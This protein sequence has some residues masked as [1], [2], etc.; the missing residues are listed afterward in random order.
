VSCSAPLDN[1][2]AWGNLND[3][4]SITDFFGIDYYMKAARP[5]NAGFQF[6]GGLTHWERYGDG[7]LYE[8][9]EGGLTGSYAAHL[10]RETATGQYFGLVQRKIPVEPDTEYRLSVWVRTNTTSGSVAAALGVWSQDASLNH[11]TDFGWISGENEWVQMSG[12]WR[13]R[14]DE[15]IIQVALYGSPDFVGE[16]YFDGL[17][18][19]KT[20]PQNGGFEDGLKSWESYGDGTSYETADGGTEGSSS[21]YLKRVAATGQY[22]GLLQRKIPCEPNTIYRLSLWLKTNAGSG[23]A[24]AGL[25]NWSGDP[26]QNTHRD[27]G[28][29]GGNTDWKQISGTWTSGEN[30]R[31]L[32]VVLYATPDFS[33]EAFFDNLA[34]K[35]WAPPLR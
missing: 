2:S 33:G 14:P 13:S 7:T 22:F 15:T 5:L 28:W 30:E 19:E 35:R 24:A 25:G 4:L 27:F 6:Q 29:T 31:T 8:R 20:S 23:A 17:A 12:I 9:A 34:L 10:E 3:W 32:D 16:A 1:P 18:L 11:H 21:A 26:G